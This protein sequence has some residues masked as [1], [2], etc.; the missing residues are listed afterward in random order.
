MPSSKSK[1]FVVK[2]SPKTVLED[3]KKLMHLA[4]YQ[5]Y[6]P[7]DQET[8]LKLNLSWS[9]FFPSCSSPS[10]EFHSYHSSP[11]NHSW[12]ST[13]RSSQRDSVSQSFTL[14]NL[15]FTSQ[16]SRP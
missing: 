12:H 9:K 7:K 11:L 8:L 4:D 14:V 1:I 13:R 6:Y 15:S 10:R 16:L 2:T 5:K 3:Y